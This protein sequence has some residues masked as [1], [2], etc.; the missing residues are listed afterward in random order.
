MKIFDAVPFFF[1]RMATPVS[2]A[3]KSLLFL[4]NK[5]KH[6]KRILTLLIVT[7]IIP[8]SSL[9]A[10]NI[11]ARPTEIITGTFLGISPPLRELPVMTAADWKA[12]EIKAKKELN[13]GLEKRS[14]P[15]QD[16]ALPKFPDNFFQGFNGPLKSPGSITAN[17]DGSTSPYYPPDCN[18][19]TGPN[20]YMQTI[21][22]VYAIYTKSG[23]L[24]AGPTNLN[25]LFTGV[26]G[27]N[28]NDGDPVIL[29]DEQADRWFVTEFSI[30]G[31]PNYILLAVS[32]T[33]DPTGS[34]YKYSF[35]VASMPDYPKFGIWRDGYYMGDNNGGSTDTYVFERSQ[36]LIGATAKAVGFH[37]SWRPASVD[38]F[39]CVPPV[40]NDGQFAPTG[41]PGLYIA[42]NDDAFGGGTD[43]L[44]IYELQVDWATTTNSTFNR[45]QQIDVQPFVSNF[46]NNWNNVPQKGTGQKVDAIPQVIMNVPQ[47]RNFGSYE[48]ILCCHTVNLG[49]PPSNNH[50]G[51]RWYELRR[52]GS[53]QWSIRQQNTF[54]PDEHSRWM[55]SIM[56]NGANCL[57]LGYSVSSANMYPAIRF[58]GQSAQAYAAA[59]STLDI[60]EDTIIN[61]Q[62]SQSGYNRWGDYSSMSV[63]PADDNTFWFTSQYIGPGGSRKTRIASMRFALAPS[64]TTETATNVTPVSATLNGTLNPNGSAAA[65]HF[66]WGTSALALVNSTPV[67]SLG[68]GTSA[69]PYDATITGLTAGSTYYY[70]ASGSTMGGS[71]NGGVMSF[72]TFQPN[73]SVTPPNRNVGETAGQTDFFVSSNIGWIASS[74]ASWCVPTASGSGNDTIIASFTDNPGTAARIA[75]ITVS[76]PGA[77]PV[78][79]LVTQAGLTPQLIV[80]PSNQNVTVAASS[81]NFAVSSNIA[82]TVQSDASWCSV[83]PSGIGNG[84]IVATYQANSTALS[85]IAR[86]TVIGQG[87]GPIVVT[88]TQEAAIPTLTVTPSNQDVLSGSGSVNYSV[89]SNSSWVA[90]SDSSWC[91]VTPSGTGDGTIVANYSANPYKNARTA[92]IAVTAGGTLTSIVTLS[93]AK[94]GTGVDE[95]E[96]SR[97][98]IWPNPNKG[99]FHLAS[100]GGRKDAMQVEVEDVNGQA[101]LKTNLRDQDE[102]QIDL[103]RVAA[104]TYTIIITSDTYVVKKKI[105]IIR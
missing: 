41:S 29:Y 24:V 6:M 97:V 81:V 16:I 55:G 40:D 47:Y 99:I 93:Q 59:N 68:S 91:T 19:T 21:N 72:S 60:A 74:D 70:R 88:V 90:V 43:Q 101:V 1:W 56:L 37:N 26:P 15:F 63:D 35:Q 23:Q 84:T 65:G 75:T 98:R 92:H 61:G 89:G 69:V 94:S 13:E 5:H 100:S 7:L 103:S 85:R 82:W 53:G 46:G 12:M 39:M 52:S 80:T 2:P 4:H 20:H 67:D 45:V 25:Q 73:L 86:I 57:A 64:V 58:C 44:W 54:C 22:C 96:A 31:S 18:G 3:A 10:Q 102:Y 11:P 33:N 38:G 87:A 42:F 104:G 95:N 79:V 27:A 30:S 78:S 8:L 105:V 71:T 28:N 32:T 51:I 9:Q 49:T 34:W 36:I 77:N 76:G 14:Y 50:A 62:N 48:T 83:T 17:F 66:D